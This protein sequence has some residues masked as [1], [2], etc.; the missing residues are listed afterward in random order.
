MDKKQ[1]TH[2]VSV[3]KGDTV[4]VIAGKDKGKKG[5]V[6]HVDPVA[7]SCVIEGVNIVVKHKKARNA[8]QKSSRDK[9]PAAINVSNVQ[10]IC[11]CGKATRVVHK[12][13][14][15]KKFRVCAKCGEVLDKKYVKIK[16]KTK[17]TAEEAK[18][19]TDDKKKPLAR[20]EVKHVAESKVK[21][22]QNTNVSSN[23]IKPRKTG[24]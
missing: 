8:Q 19:E 20:R 23:I 12:E 9:K 7:N 14:G 5:K 22:P 15:G 11:K 17:E 4:I 18:T 24:E 6:M 10:I 13:V 16:E 1:I 2:N 3:R 21:L